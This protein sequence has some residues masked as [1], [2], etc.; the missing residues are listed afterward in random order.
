M[1]K[2][3]RKFE[4]EVLE[5]L[6]SIEDD[7][8]LLTKAAPPAPY[9]IGYGGYTCSCGTYVLF[10]QQ[11]FCSIQPQYINTNENTS[12][13]VQIDGNKSLLKIV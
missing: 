1:K 2:K 12:E 4:Q 11:H 6:D 3:R 7:L 10:G 9:Y 13:V 5:R 8:A